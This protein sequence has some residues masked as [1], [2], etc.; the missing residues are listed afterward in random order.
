M[1][2]FG[3]DAL[4]RERFEHVHRLIEESPFLQAHLDA[5]R[6]DITEKMAKP[7]LCQATLISSA[8]NDVFAAGVVTGLDIAQ[9]TKAVVAMFSDNKHPSEER[10]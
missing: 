3:F 7:E 10:G 8:L 1:S 9:A 6:R 4:Q 2:A 5:I